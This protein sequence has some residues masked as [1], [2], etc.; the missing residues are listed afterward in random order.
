MNK[1]SGA[2][3]HDERT[4][5]VAILGGIGLGDNLIEMVLAE[6][7]LRC[8]Y[9]TTMFSDVLFPLADWFPGHRIQPSLP[10]ERLDETL[11]GYDWILEPKLPKKP[12]ARQLQQR[13]VNYERM[14]R[15]DRTQVENMVAI[16]RQVFALDTPT[17]ANGMHAPGEL[18]YRRF[19]ERVC[20]HPT[21]AELSKNWLPTRFLHLGHKLTQAGF[22]VIFVM[23][24]QEIAEWTG[25][26]NGAFPL[27]G[28]A[29]VADCAGF[30]Y[31][32]G[33]FIG[34]DSGGGHLA[35]CLG[36]PTVSIHG[37]RGKAVRWRP[38][39]GQVEV[40]TPLFNLVGSLLRQYSWKYLLPVG[41]VERSFHKLVKTM[42]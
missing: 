6:N 3:T 35:S 26:L 22:S 37:R 4:R 30:V 34:N 29:S 38:G 5:A 7:A 25:I 17:A 14:Y 15:D 24:A 2:M 11:S 23:S 12:V 21:S 39:W 41:T 18:V 33:F 16:S 13:W 31:E 10:L 8:G 36:I 32:S 19:P 9:R 27:Q 1:E 28:F 20:I 42:A 40:V